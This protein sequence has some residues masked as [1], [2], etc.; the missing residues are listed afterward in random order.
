MVNGVSRKISKQG[1]N[2][3]LD[4]NISGKE[5]KIY[6]TL[7]EKLDDGTYRIVFV[8]PPS[9]GVNTVEGFINSTT[10][11]RKEVLE[12][13]RDGKTNFSPTAK[14]TNA[15]KLE[16]DGKPIDI[17]EI[18]LRSQK[19]DGEFQG[20][21]IINSRIGNAVGGNFKKAVKLANIDDLGKAGISK[22]SLLDETGNITG[23]LKRVIGKG[24]K[25]VRY[26][27]TDFKGG[28]SLIK[29]QQYKMSPVEVPNYEIID[30]SQY[31]DNSTLRGKDI[32]Y[33]DLQMPKVVNDNVSGLGKIMADD[34]YKL[35]DDKVD[36][37]GFYGLWKKDANLYAD[38]GGESINLTKFKEALNKGMTKEQAAF[39]TITGKFAKQKGFDKI[40][41]DPT[42]N[43]NN[44]DEIHVIFYK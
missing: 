28:N 18:E 21:V 40:E 38:Y 32:L 26:F 41:F 8:N 2:V 15:S 35:L 17:T 1:A 31:F 7:L 16:I 27:Y 14:G 43:I 33:G 24:G 39:E 34:A 36:I 13:L 19:A 9:S 25:E 6:A 37:D 3:S 22:F 11:N 42:F 23:E 10:K 12:A 29:N 5:V 44:L 30:P 4:F 20:E